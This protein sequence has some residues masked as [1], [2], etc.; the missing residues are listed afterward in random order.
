M[1]RQ[2]DGDNNSVE[3]WRTATA[4]KAM[5][6]AAVMLVSDTAATLG[7]TQSAA[8]GRPVSNDESAAIAMQ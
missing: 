6:A 4:A 1:A 3:A 5:T 2:L 7:A 8:D